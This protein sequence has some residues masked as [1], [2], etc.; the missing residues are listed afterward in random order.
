MKKNEANA[1]NNILIIPEQPEPCKNQ[2]EFNDI[3]S[4]SDTVTDSDA[5][6]INQTDNLTEESHTDESQGI[7]S[8]LN[9]LIP[10]DYEITNNG[11]NRHDE[12]TIKPDSESDYTENNEYVSTDGKNH[13]G[14]YP[15]T[16]SS[17]FWLFIFGSVAGF[18]LEGVWNVIRKGVWEDHVATIW[19]PFCIIYGIGA[20]AMY[21]ISFSI[22]KKKMWFQFFTYAVT[23]SLIEYFS[24][25]FQ[26][27]CFSSTSWNYHGHFL[28][29]DGRIS[30]SMSVMWGILGVVFVKIIFPPLLKLL[31]SMQHAGWKTACI[32]LSIFMAV[33]LLV[34]V[35]VLSRWQNRLNGV[36]AENKI[37]LFIDDIY[38][39]EA[40]E[41]RFPNWH[42][43]SEQ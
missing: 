10:C 40:M 23:G 3:L 39:N 2:C 31:E 7:T 6:E 38:G 32:I 18:L 25:L 33:N 28:N 21:I 35:A 5:I 15:V 4:E 30:L 26:E 8:V 16:Y 19:G 1:A 9:N 41:K 27:S 13:K 17:L 42:F 14:A 34:T 11:R 20:I 43:K 24:S 22:E 36:P 29:I 37:Q 12:E